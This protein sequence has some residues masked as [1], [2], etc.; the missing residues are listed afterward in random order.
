MNIQT[1]EDNAA[2]IN[3]SLSFVIADLH[4]HVDYTLK[5]STLAYVI[6]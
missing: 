1:N 3:E 6:R 2:R 4:A 5:Q